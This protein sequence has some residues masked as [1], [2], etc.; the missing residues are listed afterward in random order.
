MSGRLVL[1]GTPIGNLGDASPRLAAAL[2]EADVIFAE[3]TRRARVLL[4]HLGVTNTLE[5]YFAGNE[6]RRRGRL[7]GLLR[8]GATVA[9]L[10][11]AGMPTVCDPGF[12]AVLEAQRVGAAVSVVPGPSAVVAALAVSGLPSERFAFEG[13]LPRKGGERTRRVE[14]IAAESRTVVLFSPTVRVRADLETL[15]AALGGERQIT[16]V[17]E[18]TKVH[19]EV[20]SGTLEGAVAEWSRRD[21]RGEF[22]L[23]VAGWPGPTTPIEHAVREV[24]ERKAQGEPMSGAVRTVADGLGLGR[25]PLYEAA[26]KELRE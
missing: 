11:D 18:L 17:R 22:T 1:C 24:L 14:E 12:T 5:S 23:V 2:A 6:S 9:L 16:V 19:E 3:D 25:R 8:A 15:A 4:G 26:L 7:A 13:F 10:A 21:P 20:W